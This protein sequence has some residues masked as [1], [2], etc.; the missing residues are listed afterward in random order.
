MNRYVCA[1]GDVFGAID[2]RFRRLRADIRRLKCDRR[3]IGAVKSFRAFLAD[4]HTPNGIATVAEKKN[5]VVSRLRARGSLRG[6]GYLG[7]LLGRSPGLLGEG[8]VAVEV[9]AEKQRASQAE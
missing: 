2:P 9:N 1:G 7:R 6:L 5:G 3:V 8:L 4:E